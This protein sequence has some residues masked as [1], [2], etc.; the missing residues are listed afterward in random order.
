MTET[1]FNTFLEGATTDN[2]IAKFFNSL[3]VGFSFINFCYVLKIIFY[4]S[5]YDYQS[6]VILASFNAL[7]AMII[8]L[9][10][11]RMDRSTTNLK[12]LDSIERDILFHEL[13]FDEA[14]KRLDQGYL[15]IYLGD[16]LQQNIEDLEKHYI[17]FEEKLE[18][19]KT[20]INELLKLEPSMRYEKEGRV[21][22]YLDEL[23]RTEILYTKKAKNLLDWIYYKINQYQWDST[24]K[25]II[26]PILKEQKEKGEAIDHLRAETYKKLRQH[27][28]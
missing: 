10:L 24:L 20:L 16:W 7:I 26:D 25:E 4:D 22:E 2:K 21:K 6:S 5:L 23:E 12:I 11:I 27:I 13:D 17:A 18:D 15:G 19:S 1:G 28:S 9:I 8:I 3:V 14:K